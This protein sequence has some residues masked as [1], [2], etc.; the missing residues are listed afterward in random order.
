MMKKNIGTV[1]RAI[2]IILA[3]LIGGLY[4]ASIISGTTAIILLAVA[5]VLIATSF[6]G[7]CPL[8][9]PFGLSTLKK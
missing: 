8:Y 3:L 6:I 2:R 5:V 9:L 4:A 1:D 7:T